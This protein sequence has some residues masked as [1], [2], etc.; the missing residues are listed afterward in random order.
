MVLNLLFLGPL[1]L[2]QL[3]ILTILSRVFELKVLLHRGFEYR[4]HHEELIVM[5]DH[6]LLK[7]LLVESF[8]A[9]TYV[10]MANLR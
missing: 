2:G 3:S 9:E 7:L 8:L 1:F 6:N 10:L 5:L 4:V